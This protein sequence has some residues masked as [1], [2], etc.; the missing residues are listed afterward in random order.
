MLKAFGLLRFALRKL[1]AGVLFA[2]AMGCGKGVAFSIL[3]DW[4][5]Y[6]VMLEC[7]TAYDEERLCNMESFTSLRRAAKVHRRIELKPVRKKG[8][9]DGR[10]PFELRQDDGKEGRVAVL[11]RASIALP[12]IPLFI[13]QSREATQALQ[14][15]P[16]LVFSLGMGEYPLMRQATFSIWES[17][18]DM[19]AYAYKDARHVAAIAAKARQSMFTEEMFVRFRIVS[20]SV[21][22]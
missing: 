7:G 9:W 8:A 19:V 2:R 5:R 13:Q 17:D 3:P 11:T 16:G 14:A 21:I 22:A 12:R 6:A 1:P 10:D 18:A 15:A 20:D 4:S